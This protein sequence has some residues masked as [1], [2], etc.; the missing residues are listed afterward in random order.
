VVVEDPSA[1]SGKTVVSV[2]INLN[3]LSCAWS[4]GH[5]LLA[6]DT[7][8]KRQNIKEHRLTVPI[9]PRL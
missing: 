4:T 9:R 8:S 3:Q 5:Y 1:E 2:C 7:Y 6:A